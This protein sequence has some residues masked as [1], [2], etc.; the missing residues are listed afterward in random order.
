MRRLLAIMMVLFAGPA[1][2][3]QVEEPPPRRSSVE[4]SAYLEPKDGI[5]VGQLVLRIY[6]GH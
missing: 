2:M 1:A 4:I 5:F 3:A 6:A